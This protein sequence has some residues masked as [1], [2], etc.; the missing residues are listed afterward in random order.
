MMR[1]G[2]METDFD[3]EIKGAFRFIDKNND[4]VVST[5][6]PFPVI[7]QGT[8]VVPRDSFLQRVQY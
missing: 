5:P 6:F 8:D 4:G 2:D 7:A 3:K 1:K